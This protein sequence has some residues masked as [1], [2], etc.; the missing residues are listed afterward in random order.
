M[1]VEIKSILFDQSQVKWVWGQWEGIVWQ[2][3][4]GV[5]EKRGQQKRTSH[6]M[7]PFGSLENHYPMELS[8]DK[9]ETLEALHETYQAS[10]HESEVR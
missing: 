9:R 3:L 10:G 6:H 4:S 2:D 1:V 7:F 8:P 5:A